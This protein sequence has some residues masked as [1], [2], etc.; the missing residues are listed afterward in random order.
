MIVEIP[1]GE[2]LPANPS[3]KN[4]GCEVADNCI[5]ISGG[6][7][8]LLSATGQSETVT[9][10]VMG[11]EQFFDTSGNSVIV[12]GSDTYLFIRRASITETSGLT[13][14]GAG[15]AWDF[16]QF[17]DYVI[18]TASNNSPQ[19][20][21]DIDSDNTWSA[22][23]GSPPSA[24][25][26]ARVGDF[27]VMGNISGAP[28]RIQWSSFN[29]P[30]ASW[31]ASRLTQAGSADLDP[32]L[33]EVQRIIGGRYATVFQKRGIQRL[34]YVG[35]PTVFRAD[36]I[37]R[38]RGA[39]APFSVVNVGYLTFFLSHDG[40]YVTNGS[41][42]EGIGARRINRWFFDNVNQAK[43][44]EVHGA[45]D[46]QNECVFWAFMDTGSETYNR[47]LIYS[48]SQN[49]WST[50]TFN[51]DWLVG[52]TLDG[53]DLDSLDAIY[54]D[55]DSIPISLDSSEFAPGERTLAAFV[56]ME[57]STF[58]G[59]PLVATWETGEFQPS[60]Q[61]RVFVSG[62]TPIIDAVEWDC[63]VQLK[64]RD[65]QHDQSTS[66]AVA[67]GWGGFA[68]VRGEGQKMAAVLTKP[69]NNAWFAAQ[70][71]QIEFEPA[72]YR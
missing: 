60:P 29:D 36:E 15:E 44:G 41:T 38:D 35:P 5:P 32:A 52:S 18:A 37:T 47:A 56:S 49:R 27:V 21:T 11:A 14:L 8:S 20:L 68:P 67:T 51:V 24:K 19:Y 26:C 58:T 34:S 45:I 46:W 16:A 10:T 30:T 48:W 63:T 23:T 53:I 69:S 1:L 55:L 65:N 72:G 6:Y 70:A 64:F 4:P 12:G 61:R 2:W 13:S 71:V 59:A 54:G 33:G 57:Y 40:F 31:A 62:A 22:L 39:L 17:N 28:S 50:G 43:I 25:R 3:F 7:N 66:S 9:E 42:V